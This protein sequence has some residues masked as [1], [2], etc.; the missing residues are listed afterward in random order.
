MLERI[1]AARRGA[2]SP[3]A[4]SSSTR[5]STADLA[6]G[7]FKV[8]CPAPAT[9]TPSIPTSRATTTIPPSPTGAAHPE[10]VADL[11]PPKGLLDPLAGAM[12][13]GTAPLPSRPSVDGRS[14]AGEV[15]RNVRRRKVTLLRS[16]TT[17][18]FITSRAFWLLE[19]LGPVSR[20]ERDLRG[21]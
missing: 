4:A 2:T 17:R 3:T 11:D 10:P 9:S 13:Q 20:R 21:S 19:I 6:N 15:L 16:S 12:A 8:Y 1:S 14:S 7:A 18:N 5:K